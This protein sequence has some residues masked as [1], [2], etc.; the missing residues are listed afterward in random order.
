[1]QK[2]GGVGRTLYEMIYSVG[3]HMFSTGWVAIVRAWRP[4]SRSTGVRSTLMSANSTKFYIDGLWV[5]PAVSNPYDVINP[6]TEEVAGQISLG[7]G[8]DADEAVAAARLAFPAYSATTR[9]QRLGLLRRSS[10]VSRR[11]AAN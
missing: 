9:R 8:A 6:A 4:E 2:K 11:G 1:M 7:S 10:R 5:K 3:R